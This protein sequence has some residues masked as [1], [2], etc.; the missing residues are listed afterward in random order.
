MSDNEEEDYDGNGGGD[1]DDDEN[2]DYEDGNM[3]GGRGRLVLFGTD[4]NLHTFLF[5]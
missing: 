5:L 3:R 1:D 2:G 4:R